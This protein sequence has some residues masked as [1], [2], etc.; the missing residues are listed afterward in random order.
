MVCASDIPTFVP[1]SLAPTLHN[2]IKQNDR[3]LN[4]ASNKTFVSVIQEAIIESKE[5]DR[6]NPHIALDPPSRS[7]VSRLR[8]EFLWNLEML[9][10]LVEVLL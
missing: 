6:F 4:S 1:K 8:H 5:N 3:D 7:T 2:K 9:K 10:I